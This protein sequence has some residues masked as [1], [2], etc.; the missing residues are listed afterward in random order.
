[1][2]DKERYEFAMRE[3][4]DL[5]EKQKQYKEANNV[6]STHLVKQAAVIEV[7]EVLQ[8]KINE[9]KKIT[10]TTKYLA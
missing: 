5:R 3:N 7:I 4:H 6:L 10:A 1:M 8:E 9:L 2:T